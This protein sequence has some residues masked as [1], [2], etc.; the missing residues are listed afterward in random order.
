MQPMKWILQYLCEHPDEFVESRNEI[1]YNLDPDLP[2][3]FYLLMHTLREALL[4]DKDQC[5]FEALPSLIDNLYEVEEKR[6]NYVCMVRKKKLRCEC[7]K[8]DSNALEKRV[9]HI[10]VALKREIMLQEIQKTP[11]NATKCIAALQFLFPLSPNDGIGGP[12]HPRPNYLK[13]L[14]YTDSPRTVLHELIIEAEEATKDEADKRRKR[15]SSTRT[16]SPSPSPARADC[17]DPLAKC[18]ALQRQKEQIGWQSIRKSLASYLDTVDRHVKE[19]EAALFPL[20]Q[21]YK[22][23]GISEG[24]CVLDRVGL[25]VFF[26]VALL[27]CVIWTCP[28]Q[29][30]SHPPLDPQIRPTHL[31]PPFSDLPYLSPLPC[32]HPRSRLPFDGPTDDVAHPAVPERHDA[33]EA[34]RARLRGRRRLRL[35]LVVRQPAHQTLQARE[36]RGRRG[37]HSA[38]SAH[39][40][41]C[42]TAA[43]Y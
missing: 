10:I 19:M 27:R 33:Q 2:A 26:R 7:L 41:Q 43:G 8:E 39:S 28:I 42:H 17:L 38:H 25:V 13:P 30:T 15:R 6:M 37:T 29:L 36:R 18:E 12:L 35:H 3:T 34:W 22:N 11:F 4:V 5:H 16:R 14:K 31:C 21:E 20:K 24:E 40:R 9:E 1:I 23:M 32:G